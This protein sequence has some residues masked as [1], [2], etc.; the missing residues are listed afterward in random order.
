[1]K[2]VGHAS[3][4]MV[5]GLLVVLEISGVVEKVTTGVGAVVE[6]ESGWWRDY[7]RMVLSQVIFDARLEML[8]RSLTEPHA[9]GFTQWVR[10][11]TRG[12]ACESPRIIH[13]RRLSRIATCKSSPQKRLGV[14]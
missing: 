2:A 1:V 13:K 14:F 8:S 11:R 4:E 6:R 9:Q 7:E 10:N 12:H 5:R 3:Q